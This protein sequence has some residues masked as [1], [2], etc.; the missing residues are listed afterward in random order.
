MKMVLAYILAVLL[1]AACYFITKAGW[2]PESE[3]W[4]NSFQL[5][6]TLLALIG[7]PLLVTELFKF[8]GGFISIDELQ[9]FSSKLKT[10]IAQNFPFGQKHGRHAKEY[11]FDIHFC[12]DDAQSIDRLRNYYSDP[13]LSWPSCN[14]VFIQ[15]NPNK[16]GMRFAIPPG[17][18][19]PHYLLCL[20][21]S[22]R[23]KKGD[24]ATCINKI[25]TECEIAIIKLKC[26]HSN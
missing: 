17:D 21:K 22:Q 24:A 6:G 5:F 18:D 11:E 19:R 9:E 26:S 16:A 20:S 4:M 10:K 14:Y 15:N 13:H 7:F 3:I 8:T 2:I 12:K 25:F 1:G 23:F